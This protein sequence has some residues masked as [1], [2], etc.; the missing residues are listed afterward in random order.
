MRLRHHSLLWQLPVRDQFRRLNVVNE[1]IRNQTLSNSTFSTLGN[2]VRQEREKYLGPSDS[3]WKRQTW[4]GHY[5]LQLL[6]QFARWWQRGWTGKQL[7]SSGFAFRMESFI[8][9]RHPV[10]SSWLV[11]G[12]NVLSS[13][14]VCGV[15]Q[16]SILL[17][18]IGGVE[19]GD[20]SDNSG[21]WGLY[22][23]SCPSPVG[24]TGSIVARM[25]NGLGGR[26]KSFR[27][28]GL[29]G[30][31]RPNPYGIVDLFESESI[32]SICGS[33]VA[34]DDIV[35][36]SWASLPDIYVELRTIGVFGLGRLGSFDDCST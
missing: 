22:L 17:K 10:Y 31:Y 27:L 12:K 36:T 23:S 35:I 21:G 7:D 32:V 16:P 14:A 8:Q 30:S 11:L 29:I 6:F 33:G 4:N 18:F 26:F 19:I 1:D 28:G 13:V 20:G 34:M 24:F 2:A 3:T 15:S 9:W 25:L 5:H